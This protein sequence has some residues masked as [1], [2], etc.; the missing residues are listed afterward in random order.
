MW[1]QHSVTRLGLASHA[2]PYYLPLIRV[3]YNTRSFATEPSHKGD[4]QKLTKEQEELLRLLR[5]GQ[6]KVQAKSMERPLGLAGAALSQGS[7][8]GSRR[9]DKWIGQGKKWQDLMARATVNTSRLFVIGT[10]AL[11][12][13][14]I[15]YAL[16]TELFARNSP[17]VIYSE[18]CK[19]IQKSDK[20][21]A[22]LLEPYR[23]QTSLT[24]FRS[25]Y[26][27]LNP[28]SHPHRPS[29]TVHSM[30]YLDPRTGEDKMM[31]HFYVEARDKDQ[32]LGYWQ[33]ARSSVISGAQWLKVKAI[34]GYDAAQAWWHEQAEDTSA[35]P[36]PVLPP[37]PASEP[38]WI[39]RKLRGFVHNVHEVVGNT[40][41]AVGMSSLDL[42]GL[43]TVP[44]TW[45]E[46]E[47]HVE[48]VKDGNGTYQYKHFYVDIP[49]SHSPLRRRVRLDPRHGE[50]PQ[51]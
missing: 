14:V 11:L 21:H 44:G 10:G 35:K 12:T 49:N 50:V 42:A 23:F 15:G 43:R 20:I 39:T 17:T 33:Y 26:S 48:L 36:V 6:I 22:Y 46:G 40:S 24:E 18:A 34:E 51:R 9:I 27:P 13:I 7:T 16:S 2:R 5:E 41:D 3:A 1:V 8:G 38:W 29:Q 37:K 45:T 32:P 47:V 25:D 30:R 31:L 28:P 19:L 4:E